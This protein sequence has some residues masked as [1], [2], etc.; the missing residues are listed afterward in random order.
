MSHQKDFI[1]QYLEKI[2]RFALLNREQELELAYQVADWVKFKA[3]AL[4]GG[5]KR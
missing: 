5:F 1:A 2:G 4:R 3:T